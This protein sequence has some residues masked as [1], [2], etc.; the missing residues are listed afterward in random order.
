MLELE[1]AAAFNK[2]LDAPHG[3]EKIEWWLQ[4]A[5]ANERWL[6]FELGFWLSKQ[7]GEGYAVGCEQKHVDLVIY[8]RKVSRSGKCVMCLPGGR[9]G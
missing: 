5:H 9:T 1:L 6:Q 8:E 7:L 3:I 2:M 4:F